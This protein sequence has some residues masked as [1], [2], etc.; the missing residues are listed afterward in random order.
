M[1]AHLRQSYIQL[2]RG[3]PD[4]LLK[5]F[6]ANPPQLA[7]SISDSASPSSTPETSESVA[8]G[9]RSPYRNPFL[10]HKNPTTGR[11]HPPLYSL[12]QQAEL[13]KLAKA[14]QV[15][16]LLPFTVKS[17]EERTRRR[18]EH[19]LRVKGT[20]VGQK[21][22]G[23]EWERT[24]KGRLDKRRQAMLDMPRLVQEWKQVRFEHPSEVRLQT[25]HS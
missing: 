21:V 5:F 6:A 1:Q 24:L 25:N 4:R 19:G 18:E 7:S 2:A 9:A 13:V 10:P 12:R 3:L 14:H 22:K 11:W 16:E 8:V 17:T 15:E 23:H 20:G